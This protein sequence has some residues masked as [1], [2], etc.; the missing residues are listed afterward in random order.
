MILSSW[1]RFSGSVACISPSPL[2][3]V[4]VSSSHFVSARMLSSWSSH[5]LTAFSR[6]L[7]PSFIMAMMSSQS[8]L[9]ISKIILGFN[10]FRCW[11][12]TNVQPS[13]CRVNWCH[14]TSLWTKGSGIESKIKPLPF[15]AISRV[16]RQVL[17]NYMWQ[18][19]HVTYFIACDIE[20]QFLSQKKTSSYKVNYK[21]EK[22]ELEDV[23]LDHVGRHWW[24]L[25]Q[26]VRYSEGPNALDPQP[27]EG[28]GSLLVCSHLA[29][30]NNTNVYY[31]I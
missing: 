17:Y 3:L 28:A 18:N 11:S 9:L 27:A 13:H 5:W 22:E 31:V 24:C 7:R 2:R 20:T 8:C 16:N 6:W 1:L 29:P 19:S 30:V 26:V 10:H 15:G 25:C 21:W 14:I 23:T 12:C 4:S